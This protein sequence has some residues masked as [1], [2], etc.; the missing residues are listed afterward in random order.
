V[1]TALLIGFGVL[2]LWVLPI[3]LLAAWTVDGADS[4][5]EADD[6]FAVLLAV[7]IPVAL[8]GTEILAL[9]GALTAGSFLMIGL[10]LSI[11][12]GA[13]FAL[14]RSLRQRSRL[15]TTVLVLAL[16]PLAVGAVAVLPQIL[17][18]VSYPS[19]FPHSTPWYYFD[20]AQQTVASRGFPATSIE[21]GV[22]VPFLSDYPGFTALTAAVTLATGHTDLILGAQ[23]IRLIGAVG[24]GAG[25][26]YFVRVW[27]GTR[28]ASTGSVFMLL[29]TTVYAVKTLSYRPEAFSYLLVFLTAALAKRWLDDNQPVFL[30]AS[31]AAFIALS[32]VHGIGWVVAAITIIATVLV[33]VPT[34]RDHVKDALIAVT[35]LA[36]TL[37]IT[38]GATSMLL[39]GRVTDV[40]KLDTAPELSADGSDPTWQFASFG[41]AAEGLPP[42]TPGDTASAT[43]ARSL[44]G[45][46]W[47]FMAALSIGALSLVII[48]G[49]GRGPDA[50]KARSVLALAMLIILGAVA[51]A[52][53]FILGWETYVPRRTGTG[54]VLQLIIF[55]VPLVAGVGASRVKRGAVR[56]ATVV[57]WF[58]IGVVLLA[59]A[60]PHVLLNGSRQIAQPATVQD[61]RRADLSGG[62][63]LSNA[64]TEGYLPAV[65][66]LP[67]LLDGRAPYTEAGLLDR[68][69]RLRS[70]ARSYFADPDASPF[71]LEGNGIT[72]VVVTTR[73]WVL[74]TPRWFPADVNALRSRPELSLIKTGEDYFVFLVTGQS[75]G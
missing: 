11:A 4:D 5:L 30:V 75:D 18:I 17:N 29:A 53:I 46:D 68:A 16:L 73:S 35:I 44:I 74:G 64:Y 13:A 25:F 55:T 22:V 43:L 58:G 6:R 70:E 23:I 62:V 7:G 66:G 54:R 31:T 60:T 63:I 69:N 28:L 24:A 41:Q 1:S 15:H 19:S 52:A 59:F 47:Q 14:S 57:G 48:A 3:G 51:V 33:H 21:W 71:D 72:Y 50:R 2:T 27:G 32:Q 34:H 40:S 49:L 61:Q 39:Q 45:L 56:T 37:A 10:V 8:I 9:I 26:F 38:W 20:L 36:A 67:G 65:F 12:V 42:P